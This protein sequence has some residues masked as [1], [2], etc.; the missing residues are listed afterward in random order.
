MIIPT[1]LLAETYSQTV[2]SLYNNRRL[3]QVSKVFL[4]YVPLCAQQFALLS[5]SWNANLSK[6]I[7]S[8]RAI[9]LIRTFLVTP[10]LLIGPNEG[11]DLCR[12]DYHYL[13]FPLF[14]ASGSDHEAV[15]VLPMF[16]FA[17]LS[18]ASPTYSLSALMTPMNCSRD[19]RSVG[20]GM[21]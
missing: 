18:S 15:N 9:R 6:H 5:Q 10:R 17:F 12:L 13:P 19:A 20:S 21:C 2:Q 3:T 8:V 14:F 11:P 7:L 16:A 4:D 1:V